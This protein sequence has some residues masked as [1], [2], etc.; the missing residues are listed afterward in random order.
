MCKLS[1]TLEKSRTK[2][3]DMITHPVRG[4]YVLETLSSW[5]AAFS[6]TQPVEK[7]FLDWDH[8]GR[9]DSGGKR[10]AS[11]PSGKVTSHVTRMSKVLVAGVWHE[12]ERIV[13]DKR[14]PGK[15]QRRVAAGDDVAEALEL[16]CGQL[17]F[18]KEELDNAKKRERE[19]TEF[20]RQPRGGL[21]PEILEVFQSL[22]KEVESEATNGRPPTNW[23]RP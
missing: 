17:T 4:D 16:A 15:K 2:F 19:E 11:E 10:K 14:K 7:T 13:L 12:S 1:N 8:Q 3:V 23:C 22:E 18:T 20:T 5:G 6:H 9:G 21:S